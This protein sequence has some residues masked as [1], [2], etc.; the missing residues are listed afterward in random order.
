M[1]D[2]LLVDDW[3]RMNYR[4]HRST[5]THAQDMARNAM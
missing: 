1:A 4:E 3:V 2:V 5:G